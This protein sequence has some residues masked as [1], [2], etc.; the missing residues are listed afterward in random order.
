MA[1]RTGWRSVKLS[2]TVSTNSAEIAGLTCSARVWPSASGLKRKTSRSFNYIAS[3]DRDGLRSLSLYLDGTTTKSKVDGTRI[4][5]KG[6]LIS[7]RSSASK[8]KAAKK[9][10]KTV[11]AAFLK[12]ERRLK[13]S[14]KVSRIRQQGSTLRIKKRGMVA[15]SPMRHKNVELQSIGFIAQIK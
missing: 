13:P 12:R 14:H 2:P 3:L 15:I 5:E 6:L 9:R 11:L 8:V 1:Q 4:L 10:S 7:S